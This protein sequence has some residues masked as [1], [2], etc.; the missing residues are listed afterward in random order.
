MVR[1]SNFGKYVAAYSRPQASSTK[2]FRNTLA[3]RLFQAFSQDIFVSITSI[4]SILDDLL[5]SR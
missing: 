4:A 3:K 2:S 5:Q 1:E